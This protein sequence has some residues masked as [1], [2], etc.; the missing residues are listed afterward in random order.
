MELHS[1]LHP[2]IQ[3]NQLVK[4]ATKLAPSPSENSFMRDSA[5]IDAEYSL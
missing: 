4:L 5:A 3:C 1:T 2:Y